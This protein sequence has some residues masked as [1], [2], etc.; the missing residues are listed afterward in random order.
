MH[1][2]TPSGV[3]WRKTQLISIPKSSPASCRLTR[4]E[5]NQTARVRRRQK[6]AVRKGGQ[7]G[8]DNN[9]EPRRLKRM[10]PSRTAARQAS[11]QK[12]KPV[13]D[14]VLR[15]RESSPKRKHRPSSRK[16]S[17]KNKTKN[18]LEKEPPN[19]VKIDLPKPDAAPATAGMTKDT[20][21][22][23]SSYETKTPTNEEIAKMAEHNGSVYR[24]QVEAAPA[25]EYPHF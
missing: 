23:K 24:E 22:Q 11:R 25:R 21:R 10:T 3:F 4:T 8:K 12:K 16:R 5:G 9:G 20:A 14:A 2:A 17:C 7:K 18:S 19:E 1:C 13:A 6:N 15:A